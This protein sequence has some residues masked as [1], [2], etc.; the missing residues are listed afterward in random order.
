MRDKWNES[1]P[2]TKGWN[3]FGT[4]HSQG[5]ITQRAEINF[6]QHTLKA[7]LKQGAEIHFV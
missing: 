3:K 1:M 4:E 6:V 5:I 7:C 2:K